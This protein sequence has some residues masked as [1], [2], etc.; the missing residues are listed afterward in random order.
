MYEMLE[1]MILAARRKSP[2]GWGNI[3]F[4]VFLAIFWAISAILKAKSKKAEEEKTGAQQLKR[5]PGGKPAEVTK[6]SPFQKIRLAL[7]A[8]LQ[9]QGLQTQ[10]PQRKL[11]RPQPTAQKVAVKRE[12][13]VPAPALEPGT[14]KVQP[15]FQ[16]L[17][18]FTDKAVRELKDKRIGV[19]V[20]KPQ[21][22]YLSKILLDYSEP[23][24]LKRAILHYEILGRPLSL[25][26]PAGHIIGL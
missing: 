18:E 4:V 16:E 11:S 19:P 10:Q 12:P 5:K 20:Q 3:L 6:K 9:R 21:A 7:E 1:Q 2:K 23:D 13:D 26:G 22:Q 15:E 24:E 17:P 8:E 25:R 14:Q